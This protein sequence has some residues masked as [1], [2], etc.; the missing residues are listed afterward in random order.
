MTNAQ[1]LSHMV[2][3]A[4]LVASGG[5]AGTRITNLALLLLLFRGSEAG[6]WKSRRSTSR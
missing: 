4:K 3:K 6:P 1:R 2:P 5:V